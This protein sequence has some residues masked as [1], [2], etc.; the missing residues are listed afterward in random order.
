MEDTHIQG[1]GIVAKTANATACATICAIVP[2]MPLLP[3]VLLML[4]PVPG[5][6]LQFAPL[7]LLK[8][9]H[10]MAPQQVAIIK[11]GLSV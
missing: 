7:P 2:L 3:R 5:L 9:M 11:N 8:D 4:L 10:I 6:L 1:T